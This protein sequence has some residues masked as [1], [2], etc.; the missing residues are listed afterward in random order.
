MGGGGHRQAAG[1]S[2]SASVEEV[3]AFIRSAFVAAHAATGA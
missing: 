1:F 3:L 2:S